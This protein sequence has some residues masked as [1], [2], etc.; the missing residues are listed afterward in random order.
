[1][2]QGCVQGTHPGESDPTDEEEAVEQD[3]S[4]ETPTAAAQ[5]V[6][7]KILTLNVPGG[8]VIFVDEGLTEPGGGIAFW[9]VGNANLSTLLD[10]QNATAL[11]VFLALSPE[12]TEP[13]QRLVEHH[14]EVSRRVREVP[15]EPRRLAAALALP[16]HQSFVNDSLGSD[17]SSTDKD[18]WAWAGTTN[19]YSS[20]YGYQS[21]DYTDFQDNFNSS[22]SQLSALG[23]TS[24]LEEAESGWGTSFIGLTSAGH[25]RAM[26][27]CLSK[28]IPIDTLEGTLN[29]R[30]ASD[31]FQNY[32]AADVT[33]VRTT[34]SN[35]DVFVAADSI[36]LTAFGQGGRFRSNFTNSGGGS[37][38]YALQVEWKTVPGEGI[39]GV[40]LDEIVVAWRS[41]YT[42]GGGGVGG[43]SG[44]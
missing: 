44:G 32:G 19:P 25:Q 40:C 20:H 10:D 16:A 37:R 21:F 5:S 8:Q 14:A 35:F 41:R 12:G 38:K 36:S 15:A 2:F 42:A 33:V 9:E 30:L 1:M 43:I 18:C 13:P 22:Y 3:P 34:N 4:I 11:E 39:S 24:G 26:A 31:C 6:D 23:S 28:A 29:Q 27:F 17:G 7:A